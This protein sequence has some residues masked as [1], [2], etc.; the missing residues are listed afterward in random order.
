MATTGTPVEASS[1]RSRSIRG[2][3]PWR[4]SGGVSFDSRIEKGGD[5]VLPKGLYRVPV[6]VV[7]IPGAPHRPSRYARLSRA[8]NTHLFTDSRREPN[9]PPTVRKRCSAR[10]GTN[11]L[12]QPGP[13]AK[14]TPRLAAR[15]PD[16]PHGMMTTGEAHS[17]VAAARLAQAGT[18]GAHVGH[19]GRT[20][21]V[22]DAAAGSRQTVGV[23]EG[24]R[25]AGR[26]G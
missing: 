13:R 6:C 20:Q 4:P 7:T 15:S 2:T 11:V 9:D 1:R 17:R 24:A 5:A 18:G 10:Q 25:G 14:S 19:E 8:G 3:I 26:R 22:S 12:P 21:G 23:G 16:H